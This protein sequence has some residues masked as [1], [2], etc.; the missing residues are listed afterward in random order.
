MF[1]LFSGSGSGIIVVPPGCLGLAVEACSYRGPRPCGNLIPPAPICQVI[2]Q[3][4]LKI[5]PKLAAPHLSLLC[6][7][8]SCVLVLCVGFTVFR[9]SCVWCPGVLIFLRSYVLMFWSLVVLVSSCFLYRDI[10]VSWCFSFLPFCF[11]VILVFYCFVSCYFGFMLFWR[12]AVLGFEVFWCPVAFV[13]CCFG[14]LVFWCV[15]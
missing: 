10:L 15:I 7:L 2:P 11:P 3:I 9:C 6:L 5:S 4:N 8:F 13:S 12:P 1:F 14:V